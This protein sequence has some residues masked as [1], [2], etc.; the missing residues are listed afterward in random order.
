MTILSK[1]WYAVIPARAGSKSIK[2]KNLLPYRGIPLVR[3]SIELAKKI[4][5]ISNVFVTTD[6]EDIIN[7]ANSLGAVAVRRP[8]YASGDDQEI[9]NIYTTWESTCG[10]K[11]A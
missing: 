3:H 5:Q 2:N 8:K 4:E 1:H 10:S 7:I 9:V 6:S 11:S